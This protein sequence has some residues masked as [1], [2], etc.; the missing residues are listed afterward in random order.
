MQYSYCTASERLALFRRGLWCVVVVVP[1]GLFR[2][3]YRV[4][5][6]VMR[7]GVHRWV[8]VGEVGHRGLTS[9]YLAVGLAQCSAM[10]SSSVQRFVVSSI[11]LLRLQWLQ[12][13]SLHR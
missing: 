5:V 6:V 13:L 2:G 9:T 11:A 7:R 4:N 12:G 8:G 10:K 1:S 3:W